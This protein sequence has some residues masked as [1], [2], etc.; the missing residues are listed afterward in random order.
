MLLSLPKQ[1]DEWAALL[2]A[3]NLERI[4]ISYA[5]GSR[6]NTEIS[7]TEMNL[8]TASGIADK[9]AKSDSLADE[10]TL[11]A[12]LR[13]LQD[14]MGQIATELFDVNLTD[15]ASKKQLLEWGGPIGDASNKSLNRLFIDV[16][17]F[18]W[19]KADRIDRTHCATSLH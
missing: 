10:I 16:Y 17:E 9:L 18:V 13:D 6:I 3:V 19:A 5:E 15:D 4:P 14:G 8:D 1:T 2:K 7:T 12:L 11:M